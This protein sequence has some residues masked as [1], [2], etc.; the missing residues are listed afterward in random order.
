MITTA[1]VASGAVNLS[2]SFGLT[3]EGGTTPYTWQIASGAL[4][5]GLQ[6]DSRSG[7]ISGTPT[8]AGQN[9]FSIEVVDSNQRSSKRAFTIS[10]GSP[11]TAGLS[12]KSASAPSGTVGTAYSF[13]LVA[14]GGASPYTWSITS[15]SLPTGLQ[16]NGNTG[17]ISG[18]PIT[19]GSQT[20]SVNVHDA[21]THSASMTLTF[22][23]AAKSS[24]PLAIATTSIAPATIDAVYR[25]TLAAQGGAAPYTWSIASGSLPAGLTLDSA[26]GDIN[27]TPT[28]SGAQTVDFEVRDSAAASA[29]R[30]FTVTANSNTSSYTSYYVDSIAGS[31]ANNGTSSSSP[32]RT[33]AKVNSTSFS[34]GT[35][36]LFKK[37]DLW[38]ETLSPFASGE[39]GNPI[40]FDAYG[41]GAA[42][43]LSGANLLPQSTWTLCS[44]CQS[45]VWRAGASA[46]PNI[47]LFNGVRGNAKTSISAL[48]AAGDWYW[49]SDVLYVWAPLNPGSSYAT[50][51]A[52][53]RI[54]VANLSALAYLTVQNLELTGSNG[55]PTNGVVYAHTQNGVSPH[56]LMLNN[57]VLNNGAG[58]GVH[59]E[60]CN[61]CTVQAS[62]IS[63]MASDGI[64]VVSLSTANPITS[65]S[66]LGNTVTNN[67]HDGIATYGCAIGGNCQGF[68]F[69]SGVFLSGIIISG[70][71]VHDN[72]E[73]IYLEWTNHSMVTSNAAYHNIRTA[74]PAAEGGGIELE[75]SSNN[76]IQKNLIYANRL[77]GIELSNDSGAGGTL[78]GASYNLIQYNAIH[79]NGGHGF[80]TDAAPSRSNQFLYNVVWNQVNG[81]CVIADG[82]GHIFYGNVCW[83]NSTGIDLYTSTSTTQT[84][85]ISIKNNIIS[86]SITRAVRI[87]SGVDTATVVFDHNN[88]DF[89]SGGEFLLFGTPYTLSGWRSAT[90]FDVHSFVADPGF[91]SATPLAAADFVLQSNSPDVGAGATLGSPFALGLA[92]SSAWPS[93]VSATTELSAWDIGAF[94]VP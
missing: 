80:F 85:N 84:G 63:N 65:G 43:I 30:A 25:E 11:P 79:D 72:G 60:G 50:V 38:R 39:A 4:P 74:N 56:H 36:V 17:V 71:T 66:I 48:V 23:I 29:S 41:T 21:A 76:I 35:H 16:L 90:G 47:V 55:L 3:V 78:T 7:T 57:L 75:A 27:G 2:Y 46:Q 67:N 89:G 20:T 18:T 81:E 40:V 45:N 5:A 87:E 54:V 33:V 92:P 32:W 53:S 1:T 91:V 22:S 9:S 8:Q 6:L 19:E 82:M 13:A 10:I 59:F 64:S 51:E 70:N 15:G 77:N 14:Q 42:P 34:P 37:G 58:H 62:Q 24:T 31:D 52:G 49:A 69:S 88:Y 94:V 26:T 44:D 28:Q 83:H 86:N 68:L 12:I 93:N 61:Y 73:G